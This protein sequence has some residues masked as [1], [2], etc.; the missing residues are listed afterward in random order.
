MYPIVHRIAYDTFYCT[1]IQI[2]FYSHKMVDFIGTSP[3]DW[4]K[5]IIK[6]H[7]KTILLQLWRFTSY[8]YL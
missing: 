1:T 5:Q 2:P 3:C 6:K 4:L 8:K 7:I